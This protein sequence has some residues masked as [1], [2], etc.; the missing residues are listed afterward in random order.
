MSQI[1][2]SP[3]LELVGN[4]GFDDAS[5]WTLFDS[6]TIAGG[7]M[8]IDGIIAP[9]AGGF[10]TIN[11]KIHQVYQFRFDITFKAGS[12]LELI[13]LHFGTGGSR[14][15]SIAYSQVQA[16]TFLLTDPDGTGLISLE[17]TPN[18]DSNHMHIDNV[19]CKLY[20]DILTEDFD[21]NV[22]EDT[23]SE[24]TLLPDDQVM[25]R[26]VNERS[27]INNLYIVDL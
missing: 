16:V 12:L 8:D 9:F 7:V 20:A 17:T 26:L 21:F 24:T 6:T 11:T 1:V 4:G 15:S 13:R 22:P 25:M 5:I 27:S 2:N 10:Q 3:P 18:V 14:V 23:I 19:S